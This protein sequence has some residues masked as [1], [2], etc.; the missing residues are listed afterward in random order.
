MNI[1]IIRNQ[2]AGKIG[3]IKHIWILKPLSGI[4]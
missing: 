2:D 4:T 1:E 3:E